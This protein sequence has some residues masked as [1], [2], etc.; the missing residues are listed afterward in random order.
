MAKPPVSDFV[1][2]MVD[3]NGPSIMVAGLSET[4]QAVVLSPFVGAFAAV[5]LVS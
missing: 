2:N 4:C 1:E 3:N 5:L